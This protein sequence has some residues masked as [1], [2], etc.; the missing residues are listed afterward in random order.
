MGEVHAN[1]VEASSAEL[2]DGLDRVCLGP[3]GAD[4]G[5]SA[6]VLCRLELAGRGRLV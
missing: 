4:N 1:N 2:V 3:D 5:G 6:V